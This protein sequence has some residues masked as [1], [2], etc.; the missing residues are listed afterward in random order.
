[1]TAERT[2]SPFPQL[3]YGTPRKLPR[4]KSLPGRVVVLDVAF[5]AFGNSQA[6]ALLEPELRAYE[7]YPG[8][9]AAMRAR[10]HV[11]WRVA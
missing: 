8:R 7:D 9:L 5:A 1:M 4:A 10:K 2:A 3:A 11:R 6:A